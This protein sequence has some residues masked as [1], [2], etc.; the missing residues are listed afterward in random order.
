MDL[1]KLTWNIESIDNKN[2]KAYEV[3]K[4]IKDGLHEKTKGEL[5]MYIDSKSS[6]RDG[7]KYVVSIRAKNAKNYP[8]TFAIL[9]WQDVNGP[10]KFLY[11]NGDPHRNRKMDDVEVNGVDEL[12][13]EVN[14]LMNNDVMKHQ[15][16]ILWS[17]SIEHGSKI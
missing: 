4:H 5:I 10:W 6:G 8:L 3:F 1:S 7:E 12:I 9:S 13:E 15:L 2:P 16:E 11:N 14:K 17:E